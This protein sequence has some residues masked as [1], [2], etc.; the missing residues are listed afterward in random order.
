MYPQQLMPVLATKE[1]DI[2]AIADAAAAESKVVGLFS[3]R[4]GPEE[5]RYDGEL[6]GIG[7]AATI[8]RMAK[9][10]DGSVHA[11]LQGVARIRLVGIE[12]PEPWMRGHIERLDDTAATGLEVEAMMRN[13][14]AIF[15]RGVG[16]SEALPKELGAAVGNVSEPS[17]LSDF[18]AANLHITPEQRQQVLAELDVSKRLQLVI[19]LLRP[20]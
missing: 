13:A 14:V 20:Q 7:T 3:Q 4:P 15:Q 17:A 5:G 2:K 8:V 18:I 1:K 16:M 12:Q 9:A 6:N 19:D 11:I 10:P